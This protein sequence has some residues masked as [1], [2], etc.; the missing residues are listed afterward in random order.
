MYNTLRHTRQEGREQWWN[1]VS[2]SCA[3]EITSSVNLTKKNRKEKTVKLKEVSF[4]LLW[5]VYAST[6][7]ATPGKRG[8]CIDN[9]S[10]AFLIVLM[11]HYWIIKQ[12]E[13]KKRYMNRPGYFPRAFKLTNR[14]YVKKECMMG[15]MALL[16]LLRLKQQT[17][18][19][20]MWFSFIEPRFRGDKYDLFFLSVLFL[21][22]HQQT[23]SH[24]QE[25]GRETWLRLYVTFKD[26]TSYKTRTPGCLTACLNAHL[27]LPNDDPPTPPA[28][29]ASTHTAWPTHPDPFHTTDS[30]LY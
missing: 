13:R 1:R 20:A 17:L 25:W 6:H 15:K 19:K 4:H 9:G 12:R 2:S 29:N 3:V 30:F 23:S 8:R 24:H 27:P 21:N 18:M 11:L 14:N 26:T 16:I 28:G 5:H 10:Q 7:L 22:L